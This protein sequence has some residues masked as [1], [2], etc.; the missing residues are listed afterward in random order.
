[1]EQVLEQKIRAFM[2][3]E[4]MAEA[5]ERVLAGVSGGA[6]SVCLLLVLQALS[7]QM[8]FELE[9]LHIEHGIRGA[10]SLADAQFTKE[11]CSRLS[12]PF[13]LEQV[14]VPD[15]AKIHHMGIEEA[16]RILRYHVFC[17]EAGK[18]NIPV[19][20]ALA[21]HMGDNAETILFRMVRG[22][23]I[24]GLRGILPVA[25]YQGVSF[26]RPL[27]K[28]S[29]DEIERYL[30]E[31]GQKYCIDSTN[32]DEAYSRNRI[33]LRIL[34]E[35]KEINP[36]AVLHMVQMEEQFVLIYDYLSREAEKAKAETVS[37]EG[38]TLFL[39]TDKLEALHPAIQSEVV[40]LAVFEAAGQKKDIAEIHI[41]EVLSLLGRQPG[42]KISL[43]YGIVARL[44]QYAILLEREVVNLKTESV[45]FAE[46]SPEFLLQCRENGRKQIV[47]IE[48]A[49]A[50]LS[51]QVRENLEKI[52]E[53]PKK[54]YTKLLDYDKIKDGFLVRSRKQGDY[55]ILNAQGHH[56]KLHRYMIDE[57]IPAH[58]RAHILLLAK[59]N[60]IVWMIGGRISEN[61]KVTEET[62]CI[63]E[64]TYNGGN[65]DGVS[66]DT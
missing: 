20:V 13:V 14:N 5:G 46:I 17:R 32:N 27:L 48:G 63:L 42:K 11:L 65:L 58:E 16:A 8:G 45:V 60:E 28:T 55:F 33:R 62:T 4:H 9:V 18:S 19:R 64:I 44:E 29:R 50:C 15:Y 24:R 31:K 41:K 1:M 10:E 47:S 37:R 51:F 25:E 52:E 49:D 7:R 43:P 53:I 57:K 22:S 3:Q 38:N 36:N 23:G 2:L 61:Y 6:D 34:P 35:L 30:L 39:H 56:K 12:I 59:E 26:I 66:E 54:K 21:H 40:R